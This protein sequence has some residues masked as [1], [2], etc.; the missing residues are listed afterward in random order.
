MQ[1]TVEREQHIRI[2]VITG[3]ES[4]KV[5]AISECGKD[6]STEPSPIQY[7]PQVGDSEDLCIVSWVRVAYFFNVTNLWR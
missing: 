2:A 7:L 3:S 6:G 5:L 4:H 1:K